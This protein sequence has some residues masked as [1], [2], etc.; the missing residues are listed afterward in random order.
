MAQ[1]VKEEL[2]PVPL[3][4]PC[5]GL[6]LNADQR[7]MHLFSRMKD[8]IGAWLQAGGMPSQ[9]VAQAAAQYFIDRRHQ[10]GSVQSGA[11][12]VRGKHR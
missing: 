7:G 6:D 8:C 1:K 5:T 12:G 4:D 3:G 2:E 11:G 9:Q 10:L